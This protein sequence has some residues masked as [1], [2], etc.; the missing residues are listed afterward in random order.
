M[1]VE[2]NSRPIVNA[3]PKCDRA[4]KS[5]RRSVC[6]IAR[7]LDVLGN[8]WTLLIIRDMLCG[9]ARYR[10]F[11]RSSERI[12]TN[13]LAARLERLLEHRLVEAAAST[14]RAGSATYKLT[15]R[16]RVLFLVLEAIRD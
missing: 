1:I 10:D 14:E 2:T 8:K 7:T 15:A 12:A 11:L 6:T 5:K 9:K 13:I 4:A 16:G 3:G